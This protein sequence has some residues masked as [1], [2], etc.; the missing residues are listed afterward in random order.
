[1]DE[2]NKTVYEMVKIPGT[3]SCWYLTMLVLIN[4]S[5]LSKRMEAQVQFDQEHAVKSK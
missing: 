4:N 5:I 1:M 3:G 2:E